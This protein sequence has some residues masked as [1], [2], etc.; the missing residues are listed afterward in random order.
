[1]N[2]QN[3]AVEATA[4]ELIINRHFEAPPERVFAAFTRAEHLA[5]WFGPQGGS[6]PGAETNVRVGGRYTLPIVG[7]ESGEVHTVVGEYLEIVE[8]EKLAFT[9]AWL[10]DDG[11]PGHKMT[12]SVTFAPS[13]TGTDLTLHQTDFAD[14]DIR[15]KH[16]TGW[17]SSFVCLDA[18]LA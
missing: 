11:E 14:A 18:F 3:A 1:M 7:D 4:P 17:S 16:N 13:G 12:V 15:D 5:E 6:C 9:W 8:N 2:V 10:D